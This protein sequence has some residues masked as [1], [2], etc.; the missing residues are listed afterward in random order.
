MSHPAALLKKYLAELSARIDRLD[1][2]FDGG[3]RVVNEE[4]SKVDAKLDGVMQVTNENVS[5]LDAKLDGR[6]QTVREEVGKLEAKFDGSTRM[7]NEKIGELNKEKLS[8]Q[9]FREFVEVFNKILVE[10]FPL[11]EEPVVQASEPVVQGSSAAVSSGVQG[12]AVVIMDMESHGT[13]ES[14]EAGSSAQAGK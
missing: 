13:A 10:S 9:E 11:P 12:E 7:T 5:R 14:I 6:V 2:K 4:V 1:A 3:L 8:V